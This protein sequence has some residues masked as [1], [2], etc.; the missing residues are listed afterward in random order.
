[1]SQSGYCPAHADAEQ[2]AAG[3]SVSK[4]QSFSEDRFGRIC[5]VITTYDNHV[6]VGYNKGRLDKFTSAGRLVWSKV[7]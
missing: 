4:K 2:G 3:G 5:A 6:W 1:M 7:G